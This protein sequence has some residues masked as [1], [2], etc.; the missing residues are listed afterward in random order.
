M[1]IILASLASLLIATSTVFAWDPVGHML[2]TQIAYDRLT[3]TAKAAVDKSLAEFNQKNGTNYTFVNA[4]CWMDDLRSKGKE[5]AG[6]AP[7]HYITLPFVPDVD[8]EP[9]SGTPPNVLW[10]MNHCLGI[11]NGQITDE[12]IDKNDALVM[13]LHLI[14]D[15]HQP[16]HATDHNDDRGGNRV[17]LTNVKDPLL[18]IFPHSANLHFFWDSSYRRVFKDGN[19]DVA[20]SPVF[21][22]YARSLEGHTVNLPLI[23]EQAAELLKNHP[24]ESVTTGGTPTDWVKESHSLGYDLG[25]QKL[26][27]GASANPATLD[28]TY[29]GAA[30]DCGQKR[31]LQA[32]CR[33]AE[34]LNALYK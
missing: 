3:P 4:A 1:K 5:T 27:G 22:P 14:G 7:W 25:Y 11:L 20:Y 12:K 31:I 32:G 30:A 9:G 10:G 21:Y 15:C 8:P 23:R 33:I 18:E 34:T 17:K 29:V 13:L 26:P 6:L 16:L 24:V 19:A 28:A 2:T